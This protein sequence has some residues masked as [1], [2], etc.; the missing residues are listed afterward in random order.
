MKLENKRVLIT[1]GTSGIGLALAHHFVAKQ[2]RVFITG[3]RQNLLNKALGELTSASGVAADVGT[4]EGRRETLKSA[5]RAL[6]GLDILVNNAGNVRAGRLESTSEEE[7]MAMV[8]IDLLAPMLLTRAA[9]PVLRASGEAAVVNVSS[10]IALVAA[11]FSHLC[12]GEGRTRP[13]RRGSAN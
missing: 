12:G 3:R 13:F 1:G 8:G 11:P 5:V 7:L 9:L 10:G 4:P 2:A 6:G